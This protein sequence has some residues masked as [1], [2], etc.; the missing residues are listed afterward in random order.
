VE[1]LPEFPRQPAKAKQTGTNKM[2]KRVFTL[3]IHNAVQVTA[4]GRI[5]HLTGYRGLCHAH[6]LR[7][8]GANGGT[9]RGLGRIGDDAVPRRQA[10]RRPP[11]FLPFL[12]QKTGR[13]RGFWGTIAI[14]FV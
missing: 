8:Q 10:V 14:A 3:R 6:G 2:A 9:I 4:N 1:A 13:P 11:A 7:L 12:P 5:Y